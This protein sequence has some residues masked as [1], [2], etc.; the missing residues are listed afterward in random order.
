MATMSAKDLEEWAN[1][2][3]GT[4][5]FCSASSW[6]RTVNRHG[7]DYS[8]IKP[9]Y[10]PRWM[11]EP[12]PSGVDSVFIGIN[13]GGKPERPGPA[14]APKCGDNTCSHDRQSYYDD[15]PS[16]APYN[17]W[18][19][20]RCWQGNGKLHQQSV[21]RVF[22]TLFDVE[23]PEN[24]MRST[25]FFN[26]CPLRTEDASQIPDCVWKESL[27][28]CKS[29]LDQLQPRLIICDGNTEPGKT[30]WSMLK[31]RSPWAMLKMEYKL[32]R[33]RC[34]KLGKTNISLKFGEA[35]VAP[36]EGTK[37]L[38]LP[39]LSR[40]GHWQSL[41]PAIHRMKERFFTDS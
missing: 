31:S 27:A 2:I 5:E 24:M 8:N 33:I 16:D 28:W 4:M 34:E 29:V 20:A 19:D 21:K 37:V 7:F 39:H 11:F 10:N 40:Y 17:D 14:S 25:P 41:P 1:E 12:Q 35:T 13:P 38:A 30:Y 26:V 23:N 6:K 36:L 22:S 18:L 3:A 32:E 15:C 9:W